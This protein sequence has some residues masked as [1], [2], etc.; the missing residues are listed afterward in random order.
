M[1]ESNQAINV[2]FEHD[3]NRER[4]RRQLTNRENKIP[5]KIPISVKKSIHSIIAIRFFDRQIGH[6][7]I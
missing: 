1:N 2:S 3:R 4:R 6:L 7:F 5:T